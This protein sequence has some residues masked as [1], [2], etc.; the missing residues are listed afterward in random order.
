MQRS[1]L[2]LL[3]V[4]CS[5]PNITLA[6]EPVAGTD[7]FTVMPAGQQ[8]PDV[9]LGPL[10]TLDGHF[11]MRVPESEA[12]WAARSEE[13]RNLILVATGL[14]PMPERTPL[15]AVVHGRIDRDG[16]S[17][18]RV[19]FQS[20]PGHYV[21]GL[22][23]RP[24]GKNLQ[25]GNPSHE[26]R[27]GVLC[28]HGHGGRMQRF[29][30]KEILDQIASGAERFV[31][32][33][34]T[35][36]LARCATLA[37][38]GC[39]TFV[40]DMLGYGDS[41]QISYETAHRHA[42]LRPEDRRPE[43]GSRPDSWPLFSTDAEL[44]LQ[45][46]MG[47]QTWNS[48]RALDFLASLPDVDAE[49]LG[50]TGSSGGGTQTIILGA[51]DP[52][53]KVSFPNGMVSTSM[54]GG[55]YCENVPLL[56]VDTGNVELAALM[57]PRPMACTAANDWTKDMLTDGYPQLQQ[58]Y[59]LVGDINDV[60]CADLLKFPHN[61]NYV[62]RSVMY[63]WF[64]RHLGLGID[65]PIVE[66]DFAVISDQD[67]AVFSGEHQAPSQVGIEHERA[68]CRW[69]DN[70]A[71]KAIAAWWPTEPNQVAESQAR[72]QKAWRTIL[73]LK[74]VSQPY[75][76]TTNFREF[77]QVPGLNG[78]TMVSALIGNSQR[79]S[80][81]SFVLIHSTEAKNDEPSEHDLVVWL[82]PG[83]K[84]S[85]NELADD[86]RALLQQLV[87]AGV[88]IMV[89]DLL[90]QGEL[91]RPSDAANAQRLIADNRPFAAFSFGYNRTLMA[92]RVADA[93]DAISYAHTLE[94]KA[95]FVLGT[96]EVA[97]VALAASALS[98][99]PIARTA[100]MLD[101]F[102]FADAQSYASPD[103]VPGSVKYGDIEALLA[104]V[105]PRPLLFR[106]GED[107]PGKAAQTYA[108]QDAGDELVTLKTSNDS[109][110]TD[111]LMEFFG[112]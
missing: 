28:P 39:V 65:E 61:F 59:S 26:K 23:F 101:G 21:T 87:D 71:N 106:D 112:Y 70:Q 100:I 20:L 56:R 77:E 63:P 76:N 93:I 1:F 66:E 95:L 10:K 53:V 78:A 16:F 48:I 4:A 75:L 88:A 111:E 33:G 54:Q 73:S 68:V 97:P 6:Q 24:T 62:S 9:R 98:D 14:S 85:L 58:L 40:F 50:V 44:R 32:S 86:E 84:Q 55:C 49:R 90:G 51:I 105:A 41:Q 30:D 25:R 18:E 29:S 89:V 102:R 104:L 43:N 47:L 52:R 3:L 69:L 57:A 42:S 36:T 34:Q 107:F 110:P 79:E 108:L 103:F 11:P 13:L 22:L 72:F 19:Y 2:A 94:T 38:L 60:Q 27:V 17:I 96:G 83:G 82:R 37:R 31:A 8:P 12:E 80:T 91:S 99:A 81:T 67:G 74:D 5:V 92:E 15:E 46:V 45:T 35:P 64:N 109:L 7:V